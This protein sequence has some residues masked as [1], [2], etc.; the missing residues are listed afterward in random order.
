ME[1]TQVSI[2]GWKE[3]QN[4]GYSYNVIVFSF[5]KEGNCDTCYNVDKPWGHYEISQSQK[6]KFSMIPLIWDT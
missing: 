5:K 1:A 6:D 2:S 4:V 3:M